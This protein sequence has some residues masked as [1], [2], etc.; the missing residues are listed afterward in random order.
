L[1]TFDAEDPQSQIRA[2]KFALTAGIGEDPATGSAATTLAG[3]LAESVPAVR[4]AVDGSFDWRI[5][6]GYEMGRPSIL[7]ARAVKAD[8]TVRSLGVGGDSIIVCEGL[9]RLPG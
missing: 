6:Q 2:R 5:E 8:G 1:F 7:H 4:D 9:L 3:Y